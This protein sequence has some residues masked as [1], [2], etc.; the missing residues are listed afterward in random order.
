[1]ARKLMIRDASF[2]MIIPGS[3]CPNTNSCD[4][5][6]KGSIKRIV[7]LMMK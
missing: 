6:S 1:L 5:N 4:K 3:P 2:S 7:L